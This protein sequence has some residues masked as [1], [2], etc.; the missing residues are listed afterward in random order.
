MISFPIFP[1]IKQLFYLG[2]FLADI[3]LTR[4]K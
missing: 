4:E 3:T 1:N 2:V